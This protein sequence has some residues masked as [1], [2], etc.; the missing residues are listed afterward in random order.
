MTKIEKSIDNTFTV[1]WNKGKITVNVNTYFAKADLSDIKKM[2]KI[3]QEHCTSEQRKQLIDDL[4]TAK[5]YWFTG[6]EQHL[7]RHTMSV[8]G[9]LRPNT[10]KQL[11]TLLNKLDKVLALLKDS[12]WSNEFTP[13][14]TAEKQLDA[15]VEKIINLPINR[16]KKK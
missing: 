7:S 16:R 8:I 13:E 2:L 3:A 4:N 10:E 14:E 9:K 6:F 15:E 1:A 11:K 12:K 5:K